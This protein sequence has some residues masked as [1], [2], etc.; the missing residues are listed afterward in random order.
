MDGQKGGQLHVQTRRWNHSKAQCPSPREQM[1]RQIDKWTERNRD[2]VT[3]TVIK[4]TNTD[5]KTDK[6]DEWRIDLVS[7][8]IGQPSKWMEGDGWQNRQTGQHRHW[9]LDTGTSWRLFWKHRKQSIEASLYQYLRECMTA[10]PA[11]N[12]LYCQSCFFWQSW[13]LF[14][15]KKDHDSRKTINQSW[16]VQFQDNYRWR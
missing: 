4:W 8:F 3:D 1:D 5:R 15:K 14:L 10:M 13:S 16:G 12:L 2:K 11:E 6:Q 9:H 7:W